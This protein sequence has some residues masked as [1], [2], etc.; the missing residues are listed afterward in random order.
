MYSS[1]K[2][3]FDASTLPRLTIN[4]TPYYAGNDRSNVYCTMERQSDTSAKIELF[5]PAVMG[6]D[7]HQPTMKKIV[8]R[9]LQ[10]ISDITSGCT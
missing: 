1:D 10:I 4:E 3:H 7:Q 2:S 9:D 5:A 6:Y 8:Y